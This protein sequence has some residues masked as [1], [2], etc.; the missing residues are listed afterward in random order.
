MFSRYIASDGDGR[1]M[2]IY[3]ADRAA[4][5][6]Q[7]KSCEYEMVEEWAGQ[8]MLALARGPRRWWPR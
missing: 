7:A 1:E 2:L 3:A 8:R 4:A 6:S 5:V